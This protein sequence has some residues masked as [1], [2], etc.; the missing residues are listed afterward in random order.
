MKP[1]CRFLSRFCHQPS[2]HKWIVRP[3]N[4]EIPPHPWSME[5]FMEI[6][7]HLVKFRACM[8]CFL[9]IGDY[10]PGCLTPPPRCLLCFQVARCRRVFVLTLLPA[11]SRRHQT[12]ATRLLFHQ[13]WNGKL[14]VS[15]INSIQKQRP[16]KNMC[17]PNV[18]GFVQ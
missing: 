7:P 14:S 12:L 15:Q 10:H 9:V 1:Q 16:K 18:A 11:S 6:C 8:G 2:W 3:Q 5:V 13:G 4:D 17:H